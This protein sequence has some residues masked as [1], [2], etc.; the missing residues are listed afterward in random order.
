MRPYFDKGGLCNPLSKPSPLG[1]PTR[2]M[3][4][5][6]RRYDNQYCWIIRLA[7]G[8]LVQITEYM[9]TELAAYALGA[10]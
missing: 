1:F 2:V 10:P 8:K 9:D 4:K 5:S 6:G 3:T 7:E